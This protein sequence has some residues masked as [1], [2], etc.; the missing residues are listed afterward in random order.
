MTENEVAQFLNKIT[1]GQTLRVTLLSGRVFDGIYDGENTKPHD[2]LYF[3]NTEGQTLRAEW[4]K[5]TGI[6]FRSA[7]LTA[8]RMMVPPE[9]PLAPRG[10]TPD[11]GPF[12]KP[13]TSRN[14]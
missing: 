13:Y 6:D 11:Y 5:I 3:E 4:D 10:G 7:R 2:A 14:R 1:D 9:H 8:G 12:G